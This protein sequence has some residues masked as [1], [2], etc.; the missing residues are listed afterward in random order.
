MP[1]TPNSIVTPQTPR[2]WKAVATT[3][4]VNFAS[5]TNVQVLIDE[6]TDNTNGLRITALYAIQ[7]GAVTGACNCQLYWK[8]GS[9]FTLIDS[10]VMTPS[11]P[12][13]TVVNAKADFGYSEEAPLIVPAGVGLAV[14]I[15]TS[16]GAGMAFRAQ[17]GAY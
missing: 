8:S 14:A 10:V 17:G 7:R 9:S 2:A 4:E 3:A 13:A 16:L 12:S 11:S 5:P 6:T 15:G 1:V